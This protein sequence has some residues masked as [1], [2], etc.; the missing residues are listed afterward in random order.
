[1]TSGMSIFAWDNRIEGVGE[2]GME[3]IRELAVGEHVF[4]LIDGWVG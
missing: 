3:G 2:I 1:M 4:D